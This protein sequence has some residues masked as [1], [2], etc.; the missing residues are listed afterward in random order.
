MMAFLKP[1]AIKCSTVI[2]SQNFTVKTSISGFD[3]SKKQKKKDIKINIDCNI[4]DSLPLG[5]GQIDNFIIR[6]DCEGMF[7]SN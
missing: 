7:K 5:Y 1:N 6:R 2:S 4:L 3:L